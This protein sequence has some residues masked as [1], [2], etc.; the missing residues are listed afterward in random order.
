[1]KIHIHNFFYGFCVSA[2]AQLT[3]FFAP[4]ETA[5]ATIENHTLLLIDPDDDIDGSWKAKG[6]S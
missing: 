3:D 6:A 2:I 5:A 1:M 4:V